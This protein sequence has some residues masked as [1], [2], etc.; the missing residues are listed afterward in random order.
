MCGHGCE[1]SMFASLDTR[2]RVGMIVERAQKALAR[3]KKVLGPNLIRTNTTNVLCN[4]INQLDE[5]TRAAYA[6]EAFGDEA[7]ENI[8]ERNGAILKDLQERLGIT[9]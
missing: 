4:L 1:A 9:T 2:S 5:P 7:P 8:D 3:N 6:Q